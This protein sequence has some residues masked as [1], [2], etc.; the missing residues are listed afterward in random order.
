MHDSHAFFV[1]EIATG[2]QK[3]S[4]VI[5]RGCVCV[6]GEKGTLALM[7]NPPHKSPSAPVLFRASITPCPS[8]IS[9]AEVA[10]DPTGCENLHR[11][12]TLVGAEDTQEW[13]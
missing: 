6:G 3:A 4:P 7:V 8:L 11:M 12:A 1:Q 13:H 2:Q 5:Q 10:S 9:K